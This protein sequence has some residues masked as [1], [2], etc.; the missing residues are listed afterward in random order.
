MLSV[1]LG[2][3][4]LLR[5]LNGVRRD[6]GWGRQIQ[7]N[8]GPKFCHF[9]QNYF[10]DARNATKL[11]REGKFL[12]SLQ[13]YIW[14]K[15]GNWFLQLFVGNQWLISMQ[16]KGQIREGV[17][18]LAIW[19]HGQVV[20]IPI[21]GSSSSN[22]QRTLDRK[23]ITSHMSQGHLTSICRNFKASFVCERASKPG[24]GQATHIATTPYPIGSTHMTTPT[25]CVCINSLHVAYVRERVGQ[26]PGLH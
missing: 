10:F 18:L 12:Q 14:K 26:N 19:R 3:L 1:E 17:S 5:W 23:L 25:T 6:K 20:K 15:L 16:K 24:F 13:P 8:I 9:V 11:N 2:A 22:S 4:I 7:R 21:N